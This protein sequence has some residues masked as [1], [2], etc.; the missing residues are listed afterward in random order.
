MLSSCLKIPITMERK[1]K[2]LVNEKLKKAAQE[3]EKQFLEI[4]KVQ[5]KIG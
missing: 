1:D 4:K 2:M 3:S 5:N